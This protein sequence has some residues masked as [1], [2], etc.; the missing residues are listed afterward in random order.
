MGKAFAIACDD[1]L[2]EMTHDIHN[3]IYVFDNSAKLIKMFGS[4]GRFHFP[5]GLAF[6]ANR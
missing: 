5:H 6:G 3:C 4:K 2:W 1:G